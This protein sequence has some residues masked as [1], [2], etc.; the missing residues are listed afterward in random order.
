LPLL[1]LTRESLAHQRVLFVPIAFRQGLEGFIALVLPH[2][3]Q[4]LVPTGRGDPLRDD[5]F[6][7]TTA[8]IFASALAAQRDRHERVAMQTQIQ[9]AQK[10]D[11][12]GVLA[13]GIAHDFNN[14]LTPLFAGI[15]LALLLSRDRPAVTGPLQG[16]LT[17]CERARN[18]VQQILLFSRKNAAERRPVELGWLLREAAGLL[19]ASLPP[20]ITLDVHVPT[21]TEGRPTTTLGDPSQLV[22]VL[23][24]LGTN[25]WHAIGNAPG[26]VRIIADLV[27]IDE[28]TS[29]QTLRPGTYAHI[30]V[31]DTG[32]GIPVNIQPHI[33]DPFFTTK[34]AGKGT[35]M[36]LAVVH[37]IVTDHGGVVS[38]RTGPGGTTFHIH[39]PVSGTAPDTTEIGLTQLRFEGSEGVLVVDD[40]PEIVS[41][42]QQMLVRLGYRVVGVSRPADA[43]VALSEAPGDFHLLITD[44]TMPEMT[45]LE[46]AR[47]AARLAPHLRILLCTAYHEPLTAEVLQRAHILGTVHKPFRYTTLARHVRQVLD[48]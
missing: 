36:G 21:H 3:G 15:E 32:P 34:P 13:G 41:K 23:V 39:L 47:A 25:A 27:E 9:Q 18:L 30:A 20:T 7:R 19:Q 12:L 11:S 45:G 29:H 46:L 8:S 43:L 48:Q 10:L 37:G 42:I 31:T 26:R 35:G 22:Q 1:A 6:L 16:A 28:D 33:F 14:I 38:F 5:P 40:E 17:A 44:F 2:E 24:N 4:E